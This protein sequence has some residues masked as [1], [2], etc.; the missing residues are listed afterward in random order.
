MEWKL[1]R[2]DSSSLLLAS[3][4]KDIRAESVEGPDRSVSTTEYP[5]QPPHSVRD[6]IS[7]T[8]HEL[9]DKTRQYIKIPNPRIIHHSN[10][11]RSLSTNHLNHP[12]PF[13]TH[14]SD[15][16]SSVI[17]QFNYSQK[18]GNGKQAEKK[19][20]VLENAGLNLH[21]PEILLLQYRNKY[22]PVNKPPCWNTLPK[23][24][25]QSTQNTTCQVYFNR[26]KSILESQQTV[27]RYQPFRCNCYNTAISADPLYS[28]FSKSNVSDILDINT[29]GK[30]RLY[31]HA[32]SHLYPRGHAKLKTRTHGIFPRFPQ[33]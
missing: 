27:M 8:L 22:K 7:E 16:Y 25:V 21:Q 11:N 4:V 33:R 29:A 23:H 30:T 32:C 13:N 14:I 12:N 28:S 6:T 20:S 19:P 2:S 17:H 18:R 26:K 31:K 24:K 15:Y 1:R 5:K 3:E 9:P 10:P